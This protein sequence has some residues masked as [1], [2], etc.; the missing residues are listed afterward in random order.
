MG[1]LGLIER[2]RKM[3]NAA[4]H[5]SAVKQPRRQH[6]TKKTNAKAAN[7]TARKNPEPIW[8]ETEA[9][10]NAC[11]REV[12]T[13]T[14]FRSGRENEA[15]TFIVSFTYY[16]HART[17]FARLS[18]PC[19]KAQGE[20]FSICYNAFDPKQNRTSGSDLDNGSP[21]SAVGVA[22][23]ILVSIMVLMMTHP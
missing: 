18:S 4:S 10:V 2:A 3:F 7:H 1:N 15:N 16:A 11:E 6:D 20:C 5:C 9:R 14:G 8:M 22:A 17:Y 21:V 12:V 19:A 23:C 13:I